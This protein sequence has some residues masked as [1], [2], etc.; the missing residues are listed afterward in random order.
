MSKPEKLQDSA[1][2]YM[3]ALHGIQSGIMVILEKGGALASRCST[4][5]MQTGL[6][7]RASD[8]AALAKILI[9]KGLFTEEEYS[10]AVADQLE[11]EKHSLEVE[12]GEAIGATI[13]LA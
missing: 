3:A 10:T 1:A 6:E 8:H 11:E 13:T 5:H 12:L 2:R 9:G 7:A 4:K